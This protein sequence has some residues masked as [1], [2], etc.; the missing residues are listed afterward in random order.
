MRNTR[1]ALLLAAFAPLLLAQ[2]APPQQAADQPYAMEY[3]YKV[4]WGHQ[5]EFLQLFLKNH[6]PLLQKNV[7][8][9]RMLSVKIE[10]PANHTTEDGRWDFRVTI[11]FK[12]ST[13]ATTANPDEERFIQQLWPDQ[14]R[15]KREEQRRFE[16]LLGHWDLP[17]TDI[18]PQK[19]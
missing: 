15:Y 4:Q 9:G 5:Q 2:G 11:R 14:E 8:S 12:N 13:V 17:V 18:T 16:I 6:Y 1:F 19:K 7:E 10:Q 3:Y